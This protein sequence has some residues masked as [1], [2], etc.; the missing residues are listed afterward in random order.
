MAR[1]LGWSLG[2]ATLGKRALLVQEQ[3]TTP[4]TWCTNSQ[5]P[6]RLV[7]GDSIERHSRRTGEKTTP[8]RAVAGA[9]RTPCRGR[10]HPRRHALLFAP[11]AEDGPPRRWSHRQ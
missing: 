8:C 2:G 11:L 10:S 5:L 1:F 7:C 6:P 9:G 3:F 4:F